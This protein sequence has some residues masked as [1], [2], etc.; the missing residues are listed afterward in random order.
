MLFFYAADMHGSEQV[1]RKFVN[2]A[3][4][5]GAEVLIL[6]GDITG[7]FLVPVVEGKPGHYSAEVFGKVERVKRRD[8]LDDLIKRLRFNGCYPYPCSQEEHERL[9]TDYDYLMEVMTRQMVETVARWAQIAD[10]KLAGTDVHIYGQPGNDDD[11]AVDEALNGEHIT[12]VE[13]KVVRVGD[14]QL[15]SCAWGNPSPWETPREKDEGELLE[16]FQEISRSLEPGVPTI[17]NLHVPPY[18]SGLDTGP[19]LGG[20]DEQGRAI[21]KKMG[22]TMPSQ[23]PVGSR[24]VRTMIERH[25]PLVSLHS[26]IHESR[27][28]CNIGRTL[29]INP[30]SSYQDGVLDGAL[31]EVNQDEV[32]R[33]QLV[34]G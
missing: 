26:H 24:A 10:E 16:M 6:G 30:G 4:F 9:A 8:Q 11:P 34:S 23:A 12:N 1:W 29:C 7:K 27:S 5:Y 32:L 2:A 22:G 28:A 18:D 3:S 15:L 19:E 14:Y 31:V 21:V 25:Q 20:V 17:F 13:S 33:Y